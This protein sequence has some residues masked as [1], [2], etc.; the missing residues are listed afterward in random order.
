MSVHVCGCKHM[1]VCVCDF[2]MCMDVFPACM[3]VHHEW[4]EKGIR[5]PVIG[6]IHGCELPSS[7]LLHCPKFI[8]IVCVQEHVHRVRR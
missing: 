3:H 6:V 5:Y 7:L 1:C 2:L 8:I 4:A